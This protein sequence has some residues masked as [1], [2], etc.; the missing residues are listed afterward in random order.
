MLL[1]TGTSD[2]P[3]CATCAARGI[4]GRGT[5]IVAQCI[6]AQHITA[7]YITARHDIHMPAPEPFRKSQ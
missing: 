1:A 2:Q 3:R 7:Q 5:L 4:L 6:M